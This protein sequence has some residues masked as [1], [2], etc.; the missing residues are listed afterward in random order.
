M[1]PGP[2]VRGVAAIPPRID[3]VNCDR[4]YM[5]QLYCPAQDA[6]L[7]EDPYHEGLVECTRCGCKYHA[8][9]A[10]IFTARGCAKCGQAPLQTSG[11][12]G[13]ETSR[14]VRMSPVFLPPQTA[15]STDRDTEHREGGRRVQPDSPAVSGP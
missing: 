3:L 9:C 6:P 5:A 8:P 1:F 14:V 11:G 4:S 10:A 2:R 12:S 7:S 13:T 15:H